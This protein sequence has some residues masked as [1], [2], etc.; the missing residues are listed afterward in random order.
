MGNSE[1]IMYL[2][3]MKQ[4]KRVIKQGGQSFEFNITDDNISGTM[5]GKKVES[6]IKGAFLMDGAGYDLMISR[7]P[8]AEGYKISFSNFDF[9][10]Q[11]IKTMKLEV[12]GKDNGQW[13][14][15][16]YNNENEKENVIMWIDGEKKLA[17]KM[18]M[19]L[20]AM[21]NAKITSVLK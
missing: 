5:M 17:T 10:T 1:D 2:E 20:P 19:I 3:N 11:K 16:V 13:N 4:V 14:V 6:P 18:E 7:F 15:K 12:I 21:G 8:L 9:M